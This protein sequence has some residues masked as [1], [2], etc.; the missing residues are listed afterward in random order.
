[1]VEFRPTLGVTSG[2]AVLETKQIPS[3]FK[4]VWRTHNGIKDQILNLSWQFDV[5]L[6]GL[7]EFR[8]NAAHIYFSR[9]RPQFQDQNDSRRQ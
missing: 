3:S 4:F 9:F 2:S 8:S 6:H 5:N 7:F 1:M